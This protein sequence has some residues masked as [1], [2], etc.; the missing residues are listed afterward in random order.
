[1]V[2]R[3]LSTLALMAYAPLAEA[4]APAAPQACVV[5]VAEPVTSGIDAES[6]S[7]FADLVR[8]D[9]SRQAQVTVLPRSRTPPEPCSDAGCAVPLAQRMQATAA[10]ATSLSRLGDK[11]IVRYEYVTADGRML[12]T[13]RATAATVDDL[14][15][16]STR[17]ASSLATGRP[18]SETITTSTVTENEARLPTRRPAPSTW[19]S[20]IAPT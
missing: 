9:L 10:V 4:Q 15:Q 12:M 20:H 3:L 7:T 6:G 2:C 16:L 13:D 18:I 19:G 11:V 1:M 17:V 5:V 8:L 14:E